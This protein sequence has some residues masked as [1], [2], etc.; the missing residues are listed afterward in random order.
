M[1]WETMI[2][3]ELELASYEKKELVR[4]VAEILA[5]VQ[6]NEDG[7]DADI[8]RI[9]ISQDQTTGKWWGSVYYFARNRVRL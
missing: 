7:V 8:E 9:T 6:K 1:V 4:V 3:K 5:F 2:H